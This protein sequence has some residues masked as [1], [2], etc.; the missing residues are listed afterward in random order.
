[1]FPSTP[2]R[3]LYEDKF[4]AAAKLTNGDGNTWSVTPSSQANQH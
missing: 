1:M 3:K 2:Q 4:G